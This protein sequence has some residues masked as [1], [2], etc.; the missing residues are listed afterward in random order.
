MAPCFQSNFV[1]YSLIEFSDFKLISV[2]KNPLGNRWFKSVILYLLVSRL[3][4]LLSSPELPNALSAWYQPMDNHC[5]TICICIIIVLL[6]LKQK[7]KFKNV[8]TTIHFKIPVTGQWDGW[9]GKTLAAKPDDFSLIPGTTEGWELALLG[10][11]LTSTLIPWCAHAPP[12]TKGKCNKNVK[13]PC[14]SQWH[15]VWFNKQWLPSQSLVSVSFK[16]IKVGGKPA[17]YSELVSC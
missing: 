10:Y 11:L 15:A 6:W 7:W 9:V 5:I 13:E 4:L 1:L 12:H 3:I 14:P 16:D 8:L 17:V 2:R